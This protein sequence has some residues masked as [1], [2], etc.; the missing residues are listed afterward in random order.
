M[1]GSLSCTAEENPFCSRRIRPGAMPYLFPPGQS[2]QDLVAVLRRADWWGEIIG[3]HGS[4]KSA[5]LAA[6]T[7]V[8]D[9]AGRPTR[10]VALHD[11]QRRL[12]PGLTDDRQ[13]APSTVVMVDGYEQL[14]WWSRWRL[15]GRCRR[16][17]LGLLVTAHRTVGLP[18]I[19]Q[20]APSLEL[21]E[22]IVAQLTADR[23]PPVDSGS[24]RECYARH[25]GNLREVLFDLY[26]LTEQHLSRTE[27]QPRRGVSH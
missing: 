24:I 27:T 12:P 5:L 16:G 22:R 21:A 25:R 13:L 7:A 4:G 23:R 10:L 1:S 9:Q 2:A 19:A 11:G 6:C 8:L 14:S 3:P 20:T 18:R 15:K 26:D 17:G